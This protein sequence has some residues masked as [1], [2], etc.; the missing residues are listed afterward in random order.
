MSIYNLDKIFKPDSI[1]IIGASEKEGSVGHA[2]TNNLL[3]G[4]YQGKIFP[5]NFHQKK[6]A[7][8]PAYHSLSDIGQPVDL[9]VIATPIATVPSIIRECVTTETGGVIVISAGGKETGTEGRRIEAEIKKEAESRGIRIIGPNCLGI[10]CSN[11]KLNATFAGHM[12]LPGKLAFISQ[13]GAICTSILDLSL[14][15]QIGFSYFVSIGSMLD[16]DFGDLIDYLGNDSS[17]S[18]IVLYIESL[19]NFRK[20]MSAARAVSRVKPIVVLK[21]GRCPAGAR[22]ASSHTGALAGED[23]VYDA[24]FKR[25]GIE[26]VHTVENLFDCAEL[27]AKQPRPSGPGL[28]IITNAGGPGVMATDALSFYGIEPVSISRETIKKLDEILPS[29]WSRGNPVDILGDASPERYRKTVEICM[30]SPEIDALLIILTP[31]AMTDPT[32]VAIA[33]AK[34]LKAKPCSV[35]TVWMGGLDVEKGCEVFNKS[36]IPTYETPERAIRAFMHMHSYRHNLELLQ[37]IPP[38]LDHSLEFNRTMAQGIIERA[39]KERNYL[40]T[41]AESKDLLTAYGIPVSRTKIAV[42]EKEAV[43]L[44]QEIGFPVVMKIHSRDITHKS[45][46]Q[47][48]QLNLHDDKDVKEAFRK[49]MIDV[50]SCDPGA[51][52]LG[53][54]IQ[55]MLKRPD[56]ELIIGSKKDNDFGP[57]ILFGMGGIMTE[58]LKDRAIA[59]PPLNRLLAKKIME[60]TQVYKLLQGYRN[61]P[62]AN[63]DLIE[64]ILIR[65][66]QL[67]TD[68]SEIK[69]LD[70]NPL[71][72]SEDKAYAADARVIIK[73]SKI[74]S[75]LHLVISPYPNQYEMNWTMQDKTDVFIRPVRPEDAPLLINLFHNLSPKSIYFRFFMPLK[76]LS[77]EILVR[78]TQIDY[79]RDVA[80][81][82]IKRTEKGEEMLGVSRL[83][84]DPDGREAEFA[85]A[86]GDPW[87][88]KGLGEK[89]LKYCI[90]IADERGIRRLWG[91]VLAEN[92]AMLSLARKLGFT[93]TRST[94][95]NEYELGLNLKNIH[96]RKG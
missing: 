50:H 85:M 54:T 27:M 86:V 8:I 68:F 21:S 60:S 12:P 43:R 37:E 95:L 25:A 79:D 81:V 5:V 15:E 88:G 3:I 33:L 63:L 10:I 6:I 26:R 16:V 17:V 20:F 35:F 71:I 52:L 7:G 96:T 47:G 42:S 1:A 83:M 23:A 67:I 62:P 91:I 24:A 53:V 58:V 77:H 57:I 55:P 73:P 69:E 61:H 4:G 64:E 75:P 84:S 87:Q 89:L 49:M 70:I 72:L 28:A 90:S 44:A 38:K 13:S 40:L 74:P 82:A 29:F 34:I 80:L 2:L 14:K 36:G 45:D 78:C 76:S 39:L 31:Q 48:V 66:S 59:L 41:E 30:S 18:S 32:A 56:Y 11:T 46:V 65:L 9:A 22:A 93:I 19:S 92:T 94:D 51:V